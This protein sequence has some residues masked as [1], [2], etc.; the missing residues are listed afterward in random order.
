M[1]TTCVLAYVG[2]RQ[3]LQSDHVLKTQLTGLVSLIA[4]KTIFFYCYNR[5][6]EISREPKLK[7]N[8]LKVA[9]MVIIL[10]F[11]FSP[12]WAL[13]KSDAYLDFDNPLVH[14]Y[15]ITCFITLT[16]ASLIALNHFKLA[17]E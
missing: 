9:E 11:Q 2:G 3:I 17:A 8:F 5:V 14:D 4:I 10:Y 15:L 1:L 6:L 12:R 16:V 13:A 7:G